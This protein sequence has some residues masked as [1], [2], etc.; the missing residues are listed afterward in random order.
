MALQDGRPS[1]T[2]VIWKRLEEEE[3]YFPIWFC[4]WWRWHWG[5][6]QMT[7]LIKLPLLFTNALTETLKIIEA[8]RMTSWMDYPLFPM[9]G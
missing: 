3:A 5:H 2:P 6:G 7:T 4:G 1:V 9:R 8:Q